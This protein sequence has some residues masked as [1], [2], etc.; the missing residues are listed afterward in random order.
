MLVHST[1]S[2]NCNPKHIQFPDFVMDQIKIKY[3]NF[4]SNEYYNERC[5]KP[6]KLFISFLVC[7]LI[8][9]TIVLIIKCTNEATTVDD[10]SGILDEAAK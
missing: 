1:R 6:H 5:S 3:P 8:G 2:S 9:S 4:P 10:D 7:G